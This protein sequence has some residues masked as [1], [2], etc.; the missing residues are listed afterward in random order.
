MVQETW[1]CDTGAQAG[2]RRRSG[3]VAL[4][5]LWFWEGNSRKCGLTTPLWSG[6]EESE[7]FPTTFS[8]ITL[9]DTVATMLSAKAGPIQ[10]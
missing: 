6:G 3:C 9:S 2:W 8:V 10:A 4:I 5:G 7:T 1:L